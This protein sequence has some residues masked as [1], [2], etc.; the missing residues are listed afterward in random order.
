MES[1][2]LCNWLSYFIDNSGEIEK[3]PGF[4]VVA[5]DNESTFSQI[6]RDVWNGL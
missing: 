5:Q 6:L 2:A 3:T 1:T 4:G